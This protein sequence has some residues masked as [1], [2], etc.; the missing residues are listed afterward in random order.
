MLG[1]AVTHRIDV[2]ADGGGLRHAVQHA[3]DRQQAGRL[4]GIGIGRGAVA[5]RQKG[6]G[7]GPQ[8]GLGGFRFVGKLVD[9]GHGVAAF[10]GRLRADVGDGEDASGGGDGDESES[11]QKGKPGADAEVAKERGNGV[12]HGKR[13]S[14]GNGRAAAKSR[15]I[16]TYHTEARHGTARL[17]RRQSG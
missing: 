4:L 3:Q 15:A 17:S 7:S 10:Q 5:A 6:R 11:D 16:H 12:D 1:D 14:C 9:A 2:A 13:L 8:V